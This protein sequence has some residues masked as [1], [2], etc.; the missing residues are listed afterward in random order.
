MSKRS[1]RRARILEALRAGSSVAEIHAQ[2]F[3]SVTLI[4][5]ICKEYGF[6]T[7]A[8]AREEAKRARIQAD[9][10]RT[11]RRSSGLPMPKEPVARVSRPNEKSCYTEE[12]MHAIV[13]LVR[14][15]VEQRKTI[16]MIA[17]EIGVSSAWVA[18]LCKKHSIS[19]SSGQRLSANPALVARV[20][21]L[22]TGGM[23][24]RQ[25]AEEVGYSHIA[26]WGLLRRSAK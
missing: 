25:I 20:H 26:V 19:I 14:H 12:E 18:R 10:E 7:P 8:E 16:A 24:L 15:S 11:R 21:E 5:S 3:G 4:R 1:A 6:Q 22:H 13:E 23:S 17:D 9:I 2:G